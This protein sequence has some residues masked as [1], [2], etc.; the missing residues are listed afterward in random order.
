M[1][2]TLISWPAIWSAAAA[3]CSAASALLM[4]RLHHIN[5]RDSVRPELIVS[6]FELVKRTYIGKRPTL[7][8]ITFLLENAGAGTAFDTRFA[9]EVRAPSKPEKVNASCRLHPL[10]LPGKT[11]EAGDYIEFFW[12]PDDSSFSVYLRLYYYDL[13][14]RCYQT[15]YI[16]II[17]SNDLVDSCEGHSIDIRQRYTVLLSSRNAAKL[18]RDL[19]T[20]GVKY[21]SVPMAYYFDLAAKKIE[22]ETNENRKGDTLR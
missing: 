8:A 7:A 15:T 17:R 11:T 16:F 3:S 9:G 19:L 5:R 2:A 6:G 12:P 20:G 13:H 22:E 10:I 4:L 21:T 18:T 1:D 14:G